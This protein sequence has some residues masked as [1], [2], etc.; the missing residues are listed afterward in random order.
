MNGSNVFE[1]GGNDKANRYHWKGTT[2]WSPLEVMLT[3]NNTTSSWFVE[4]D[5]DDGTNSPILLETSIIEVSCPVL[6][7]LF[8]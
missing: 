5:V 4:W 2:G 1:D 8:L 3:S 7:K 6:T